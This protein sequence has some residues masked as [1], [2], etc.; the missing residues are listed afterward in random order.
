MTVRSLTVLQSFPA[1]RQTTNPYLHDAGGALASHPGLTL[2]TS[3]GAT[4]CARGTTSST[5]TGPRSTCGV[6]PGRGCAP[7]GCSS[8]SSPPLRLRL[9]LC[10]TPARAHPAQRARPHDLRRDGLPPSAPRRAAGPPRGSGSNED[11]HPA[12]RRGPVET[13]PHGH[14]RPWFAARAG[15]ADPGPVRSRRSGPPLQERPR[16]ASRLPRHPAT[17]LGAPCADRRPRRSERGTR[18]GAHPERPARLPA[19]LAPASSFL[20]EA[21]LAAAVTR[22]ELVALPTGRCT[23]PGPRSWRSLWTGRCSSPTTR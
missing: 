12:G 2:R 20:N 7:A 1:P 9:R 5:R 3:P 16:P 17:F 4:R 8:C 18:R 10:R 19:D 15:P 13:M 14:Y 22:A 11:D 23:T 21:A 6:R